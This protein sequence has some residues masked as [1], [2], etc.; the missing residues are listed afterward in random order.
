VTLTHLMDSRPLRPRR[1]VSCFASGPANT[2]VYQRSPA[3]G[4]PLC[5]RSV[6]STRSCIS[7]K[8]HPTSTRLTDFRPLPL[9]CGKSTQ[10]APSPSASATYEWE[11]RTK[12]AEAVLNRRRR[13]RRARVQEGTRS[14][15]RNSPPSA[16]SLGS[17]PVDKTLSTPCN[18]ALRKCLLRPWQH[19][20]W[21]H[22]DCPRSYSMSR[23][24]GQAFAEIAIRA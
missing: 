21:P 10:T 24:I 16:A 8:R 7:S 5:C 11:S 20:A 6:G 22:Y 4:S 23:L 18:Q 19:A 15:F 9:P 2:S 1:F 14:A 3:C 12:T 17:M 13:A